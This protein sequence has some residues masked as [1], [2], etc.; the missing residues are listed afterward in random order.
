MKQNKSLIIIIAIVALML[1]LL[2]TCIAVYIY[3]QS[4]SLTET[5]IETAVTN[6]NTSPNNQP[7]QP[8]ALGASPVIYLAGRTDITIPPLDESSTL[9]IFSCRDGGIIQET[10][11]PGYRI[12]PQA[13]FTFQATGRTNFFGGPLEEGY[14][15]DGDPQGQ[16]SFLNAF[17][18]ISGYQGPAGTLVGVFLDDAIPT[19]EPPAPLDFTAAGLGTQFARLEPAIGQVFFIGDGKTDAGNSHIF[20]AP[21]NATRLYIGL[22]DGSFFVGDPTCYADN[23]GTFNYQIESNQPYQP[24]P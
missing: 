22:A 14:P 24:L 13:T 18:G 8:I 3:R 4:V 6:I 9:S 21:A 17:G 19:G 16:K 11:P 2:V 5:V 20:V 15:P 7:N 12:T 1:C 10:F 23:T